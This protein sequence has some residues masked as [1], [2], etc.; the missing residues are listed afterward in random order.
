MSNVEC[1]M[2][3]AGPGP[4]RLPL[5]AAVAALIAFGTLYLSANRPVLMPLLGLG[6]LATF[7]VEYRLP[8]R[9]WV[10]W[11]LRI[12]FSAVAVASGAAPEDQQ[13]ET[14][15]S[16][17]AMSWFG[18]ACALELVIQSWMRRPGAHSPALPATL[19]T[20]LTFLAATHTTDPRFVPYATPAF[21]IFTVLA[22]RDFRPAAGGQVPHPL[23]A[24]ALQWGALAAAMLL[25]GGGAAAVA[26]NREALT[27]WGNDMVFGRPAASGMTT[28]PELGGAVDLRESYARVLTLEGL[29]G[30]TYLRG[31]AFA[32]YYGGRWLPSLAERRLRPAAYREL[33]PRA[34]GAR[35]RVTRLAELH[36]LLLHPLEAAGVDPGPEA[37]VLWAR[38][39]G[40]PIQTQRASPFTYDVVLCHRTARERPLCPPPPPGELGNWLRVPEELHARVFSLAE[41]IGAGAEGPEERVRAVTDYLQSNHRYSLHS[42]VR[43]D[44]PVSDF[45]LRKKAAHCEYFASS[46]VILLRIL[47]VPARYVTG[48]YAHEEDGPGVT[49]V[50]ERDAHAWAEAWIDG[51]GWVT[52][53]A[54]PPSG[55]PDQLAG[56]L[57]WWLERWESAQAS[58]R[59]AAA[60]I[61]RPDSP[62]LFGLA[63]ALLAAPAGLLML[64]RRRTRR[65]IRRVAAYSGRGRE[66]DAIARRF[67]R[68]LAR[69]GV[70]C[71]AHLPWREHL[72]DLQREPPAGLDL[73]T[74]RLIVH[75]YNALRFGP[76]GEPAALEELRA[77]LD[78]LEK[79]TPAPP[80]RRLEL[81]TGARS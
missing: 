80:P 69:K 62:T 13:A 7:V 65:S 8:D 36:G 33:Q 67:Q 68:I 49:V 26:A 66:L 6:L 72:A 52:V 25:G 40:G 75:H 54:T 61:L 77:L 71:P 73:E 30:P 48:Y 74:A 57:P 31:A 43:R 35:V 5:N 10:R 34:A 44:E 20:G 11:L 21:L 79:R 58:I 23:T 18:Q 27:Q 63:G 50:R 12:L 76:C 14:F 17:R 70:P 22:L 1:K 64:R 81:E 19:L 46:A 32:A 60:A 28:T 37:E 45:L 38:E 42:S 56:A 39:D 9:A 24:G 15:V 41:Q 47:R 29:P 53:E 59:A 55:R 3:S 4:Q 2:S 78:R 51:Q 16:Y